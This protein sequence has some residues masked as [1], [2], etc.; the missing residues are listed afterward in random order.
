MIAD[1]CWETAAAV[2]GEVVGAVLAAPLDEPVVVNIN[3]PNL[4]LADIVGWRHATVGLL[5]PRTV[6]TGH[7]DPIAGKEGVFSRAHGVG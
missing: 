2:A 4:P 3:V 7:L 6:A 1:Q 5:P